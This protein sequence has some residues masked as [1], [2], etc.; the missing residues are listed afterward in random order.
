MITANERA[1]RF[2]TE[3][4]GAD[5]VLVG[6]PMAR[7]TSFRIGGPAEFFVS[8]ATAE[9]VAA[10]L[11]YCRAHDLALYVLGRGSNVLVADEGLSGVVLHLGTRFSAIELGEDGHMHARAGAS[12][13]AIA[14]AALEAGLAGFEFAAGI[15]GTIGGAAM[16]NAGAYGA[17]LSDVATGVLCVTSAGEMRHVSAD[18]AGW[19]Y[20][21]SAFED[22]DSIVLGVDLALAPGSAAGIKA[23]MDNLA[24][25]RRE[26]Q[27]L[28][29][30]SAG[31]TFKRPN[32]T[33]AGKLIQD[34]GMQGRSVGGAQVSTKHAGFIINTGN[35]TARD[36]RELMDE[37]TR[38]V[39]H[40]SGVMLE[41][42]VRMWGF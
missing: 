37:V 15:P 1:R 8:P 17:E 16:M 31:S 2:L 22:D 11:T 10:V 13:A 24:T 23:T 28:D 38:G 40:T 14:H 6:E 26:K 20:R 7:H 36:V 33:F 3:T 5:A 19:G 25:L 32:G 27:P 41:P 9:E 30:P 18:G 34:A 42:E 4:L 35:A 12:N 21:H 39:A 29:V